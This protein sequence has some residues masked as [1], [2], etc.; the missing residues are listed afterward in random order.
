MAGDGAV[1]HGRGPLPDR[2][3][4]L[5]LAQTAALQAGMLGPSDR[6]PGAQVI[7]QRLLQNAPGL[8][9]Q[10]P[11]YRLVGHLVVRLSRKGTL[12]PARDLLWRPFAPQLGRYCAPQ[13]RVTSQLAGLRAQRPVPG[14]PIR[15][16]RTIRCRSTIAPDFAADRRGRT[17]KLTC[18]GTQRT[19]DAEPSRDLLAFT[20]AESQPAALALCWPNTPRR[21]DHRKDR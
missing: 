16:R 2:H 18:N 13:P 7:K 8:N 11:I 21:R 14:C 15:A 3:R 20:E 12:E 6:A 17:S 9:I 10:A 5:D 4:I 1:F 19:L